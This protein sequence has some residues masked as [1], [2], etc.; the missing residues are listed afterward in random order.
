VRPLA[1]TLQFME[2]QCPERM[3]E[4][5]GDYLGSVQGSSEP[6]SEQAE[7]IVGDILA[8]RARAEGLDV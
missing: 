4:F 7:A 6:M 8:E 2:R 5:L 1:E 3:S